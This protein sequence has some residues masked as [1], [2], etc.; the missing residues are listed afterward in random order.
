M[1]LT[2]CGTFHSFYYLCTVHQTLSKLMPFRLLLSSDKSWSSKLLQICY[3]KCDKSYQGADSEDDTQLRRSLPESPGPGGEEFVKTKF[4]RG[5]LF[6]NPLKIR[7]DIIYHHP[8]QYTDYTNCTN[9]YE[10]INRQQ[11]NDLSSSK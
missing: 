1:I 5:R 6:E 9:V 2:L 4:G 7:P 8:T 10:T 3:N 11:K